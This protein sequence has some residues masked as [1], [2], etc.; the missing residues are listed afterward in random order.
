[1]DCLAETQDQLHQ[2][3]LELAPPNTLAAAWYAF[4]KAVKALANGAG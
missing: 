1:M 3:L 2:C 4:A